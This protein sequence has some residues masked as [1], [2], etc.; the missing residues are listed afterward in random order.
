MSEINQNNESADLI[1]KNLE[2]SI[3]KIDERYF[4]RNE[5]DFSYE[6]YYN[7]RKLAYPPMIEVSCE[8]SKNRF[9]YNDEIFMDNLIKKCFFGN[10][11]ENTRINRYPDLIVHQYGTLSHQHLAIEIKKRI[12]NSLVLRDLAKLVVY[13]RGSLNY[14]KG[15]LIIIKPLRN[16]IDIPNVKKLL[17]QYPEIEIWVVKPRNIQV[18]NAITLK[19]Q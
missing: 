4:D 12:N 19:Q 1:T 17:M 13:C 14:K 9:S 7:M 6:L 10:D 3:S 2:T 15:I 5:R 8:T 18:I 16:I 11:F